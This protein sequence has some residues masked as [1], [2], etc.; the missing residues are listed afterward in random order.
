MSA[1]L[2]EQV[3]AAMLEFERVWPELERC[4]RGQRR[5]DVVVLTMGLIPLGISL[6]SILNRPGTLLLIATVLGVWFVGFAHGT[7][8]RTIYGRRAAFRE[9]RHAHEKAVYYLAMEGD[10]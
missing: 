6:Y 9:M 8:L 5:S 2:P 3:R 4:E 1:E 10:E 7:V